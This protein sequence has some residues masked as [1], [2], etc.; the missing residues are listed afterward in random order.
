MPLPHVSGI[1][2]GDMGATL[3]VF[4]FRAPL[5]LAMLKDVD[6]TMRKRSRYR[7]G[8]VHA[9]LGVITSMV[10]HRRTVGRKG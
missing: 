10:A 2:V 3:G 4:G 9:W 8:P 5:N 7:P 6:Y 1:S